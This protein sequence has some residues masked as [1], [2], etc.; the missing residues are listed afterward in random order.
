MSVRWWWRVPLALVLGGCANPNEAVELGASIV[1]TATPS[2]SRLGDTVRVRM[3]ITNIGD[4]AV[5]VIFSGC[6]ND[7]T[8]LGA[9][10]V[11]YYPAEQVSCPFAPPPPVSL[12]PGESTTIEE[13]TTGRVVAEDT[14]GPPVLLPAGTYKVEPNIVVIRGDEDG[15]ET[16]RTPATVTFRTA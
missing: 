7:F 15:V 11:R 13:F 16:R 5:Q 9:S 3:A 8:L 2:T 14:Q 6:N 10:G 1:T 12:A 4:V